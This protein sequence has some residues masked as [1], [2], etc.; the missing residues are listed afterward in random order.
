[1][2]TIAVIA[3]GI[4]DQIFIE[5]MIFR[6][7]EFEEEPEFVYAQP[8]RDISHSHTA[9]HGGWELVL[10]Y[11]ESHFLDAAEANDFILIQIDTDSGDH[12]NFGINLSPGGVDRTD[13][14]LRAAAI[15]VLESKIG[16]ANLAK[17]SERTIFAVCVHSLECWIIF[18]LFQ[19]HKKKNAFAALQRKIKHIRFSKTA[20]DYEDIS[21]RI[22]GSK[23]GHLLT[24]DLSLS[25]FLAEF[26]AK[27][28][29]INTP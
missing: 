2:H 5:E 6:I 10:E 7:F 14:E 24:E 13:A 23:F 25:M 28:P 22:D 8:A 3:E 20:K 17:F 15:A 29:D 4:T 1:M 27:F 26:K 21:R 19:S 9:P 12:P 16:A 11:C 18:C